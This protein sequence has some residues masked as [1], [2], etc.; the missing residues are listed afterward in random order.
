MT[1][2]NNIVSIDGKRGKCERC[3]A[4]NVTLKLAYFMDGVGAKP[5]YVCPECVEESANVRDL[6][7]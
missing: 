4:K 6:Y 2:S 3:D 1:N 5:L 7:E